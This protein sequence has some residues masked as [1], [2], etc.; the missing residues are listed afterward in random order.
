[1]FVLPYKTYEWKSRGF[2]YNKLLALGLLDELMEYERLKLQVVTGILKRSNAMLHL[3][4]RMIL[5][6]L[7]D[8]DRVSYRKK[9]TKFILLLLRMKFK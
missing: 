8:N 6:S 3:K 5:M 4:M 2:K 9:D 1:M 7:V